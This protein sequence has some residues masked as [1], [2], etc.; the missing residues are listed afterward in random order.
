MVRWLRNPQAIIPGNAM[1]DMN[2]NEAQARDI[3]TY[4]AGLQ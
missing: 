2:L 4:L 3:T 1:P